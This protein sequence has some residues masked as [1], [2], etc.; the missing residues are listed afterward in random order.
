MRTIDTVL[1]SLIVTSVM[2][3]KVLTLRLSEEAYQ[4]ATALAEQRQQSLNRLFQD[5]LLLLD[6]QE[7]DKRLFDDFTAIAESGTNETDV[8]F[9][10]EAQT[11][12]IKGQ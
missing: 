8:E 2:T 1:C 6:Q 10:I 4:R 7:R 3:A 5:G 12:A 9:A 11:R